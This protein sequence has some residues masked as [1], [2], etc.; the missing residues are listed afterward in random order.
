MLYGEDPRP[1]LIDSGCMSDE[2]SEE[3][4]TEHERQLFRAKLARKAGLS[5]AEIEAKVKVW[6]V[7]RPAHRADA[8]SIPFTYEAA[9]SSH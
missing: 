3:G 6:E 5:P 1:W 2:I 8:V 9:C 4:E 7:V